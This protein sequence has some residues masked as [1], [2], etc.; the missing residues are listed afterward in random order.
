MLAEKIDY[1]SPIERALYLL[2]G[3]SPTISIGKEDANNYQPGRKLVCCTGCRQ[4][5]I[6]VRDKPDGKPAPW[7]LS[8][9]SWVNARLM[10]PVYAVMSQ[11]RNTGNS[12]PP[13]DLNTLDMSGGTGIS[14]E[15]LDWLL[16]GH[17]ATYRSD[18]QR[19]HN[20][21]LAIVWSIYYTMEGQDP[22]MIERLDKSLGR[23]V[24][25]AINLILQV[26]IS[27]RAGKATITR[28]AIASEIGRDHS[29]LS[30]KRAGG[31]VY[32]YAKSQIERWESDINRAFG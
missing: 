20:K 9:Q 11:T 1:N 24:T 13:V 16:W 8:C 12:K 25:T 32:D 18:K 5:N 29:Y 10:L 7:C 14:K 23:A 31:A 3:E 19:E 2:E 30:S 27:S 15:A 6:E 28:N 21:Q 22:A 26:V 17:G 4:P